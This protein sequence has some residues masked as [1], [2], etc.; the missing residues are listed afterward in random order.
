MTNTTDVN[1]RDTVPNQIVE[2]V[3]I[4]LAP[5]RKKLLEK[6]KLWFHPKSTVGLISAVVDDSLAVNMQAAQHLYVEY[7]VSDTVHKDLALQDEIRKATRKT[8]T[9]AF[10]EL[11]VT[12][13]GLEHLLKTT[14][15]DDVTGVAITGLGASRNFSVITMADES[16]RLCIGKKLVTL[17]NATFGVADSIDIQFVKH[18][19]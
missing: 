15:G 8:L 12:R 11:Q 4:T 7:F 1:Y 13:N 5:T 6:T 10:K 18:S 14:M 17:P 19:V 16:S 3:N 2:W 9:A